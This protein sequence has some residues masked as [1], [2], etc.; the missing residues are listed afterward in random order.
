M[1]GPPTYLDPVPSDAAAGAR[2]EAACRAATSRIAE[3]RAARA[4]LVAAARRDWFGPHREAF[5]VADDD[6]LDAMR[7]AGQ[8]VDDLRTRLA[9]E[10][11]ALDLDNQDRARARARWYEEQACRTA[12]ETGS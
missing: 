9:S 3:V 8:L 5:D 6:L 11:W 1:S 10:Q 7:L 4:R 12:G 2:L